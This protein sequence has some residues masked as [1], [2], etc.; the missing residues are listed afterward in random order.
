[1]GIANRYFSGLHRLNLRSL[2]L[3]LGSLLVVALTASFATAQVPPDAGISSA[4][5]RVATRLVRPDVFEENGKIQGFSVD[6]AQAVVN[7]MQPGRARSIDIQTYPGVAEVLD[8]VRRGEADLALGAIA[9]TSQREQTFDFSHPILLAG[10]QIMVPAADQQ[11]RQ[12]GREILNR[13]LQPDLLKLTGIVALLMLFPA[14][15][16]WYFERNNAESM[17]EHAAYI[18]GIFEALWWTVLALVG[19][20][21]DMPEGPVGKLVA[22][23]W[24][25][26]GI[27]YLTY[28]TAGLTADLALQE[29]QG[30]I[31]TLSD[32]QNRPV[33]LVADEGALEYLTDQN[34]RQITRFAQPEAAYAALKAQTVEAMIAPRPLLLYFAAAEPEAR[35][36]LVGTPFLDQFYAIAMPEGSP[37]RT[38]INQ[39]ILT[40]RENGTYAEIHRQ[41]FGVEP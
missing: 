39:A 34:L 11:T 8:A 10:L 21:E 23:F 30:N 3:G 20:A 32:L 15:V 13:I 5:L 7:Q 33:A 17:I 16:L 4:P 22:V 12:P 18:P 27:I 1:M 24:V 25:F 28:F 38:P 26:V 14:H 41:W 31:Q 6:V 9:L 35:F 40:L 19:Q 2:A 37:Y 29:I 36:Q